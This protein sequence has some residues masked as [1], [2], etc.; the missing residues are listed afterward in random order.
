MTRRFV[1]G[2]KQIEAMLR[3][4]A[5]KSADKVAR[6]AL[7]GGTSLA[8]KKIRAAAPKGKTGL[9]R[10][11]IRGVVK[12]AKKGRPQVA[13]VGVNV[14]AKREPKTAQAKR[15][16]APHSHLVLLGTQA[17]KRRRIG[18]RYAVIRNPSEAQLRTGRMPANPFLRRTFEASQ[19]DIRKQMKTRAQRALTREV[20]RLKAGS[21]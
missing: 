20:Q 14:G 8:A 1:T 10:K 19:P 7:Q 11:S 13:K 2:D 16:R 6:A 18:G 21:R 4:L 12:R 9:L 15:K 5:D 17:R 3:G